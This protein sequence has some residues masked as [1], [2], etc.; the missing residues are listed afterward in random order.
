MT[1]PNREV[2]RDPKPHANPK[3]QKDRLW[4]VEEVFV[5]LQ[6]D[7]CVDSI[8]MPASRASVL[9]FE[10]LMFL[11]LQGFRVLGQSTGSSF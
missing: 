3:A 8:E 4:C 6:M 2:Y 7:R 10:G 1:R 11:W 9:G 5:Y